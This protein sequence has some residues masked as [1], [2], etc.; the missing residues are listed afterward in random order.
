MW[1]GR[2]HMQTFDARLAHSSCVHCIRNWYYM[3]SPVKECLQQSKSHVHIPG[4]RHGEMAH[5]WDKAAIC[6]LSL[7]LLW[8]TVYISSWLMYKELFIATWKLDTKLDA[9]P[10]LWPYHMVIAKTEGA[11]L[12][13]RGC[14]PAEASNMAIGHRYG[15]IRALIFSWMLDLV[16]LV[17]WNQCS[18]KEKV[19]WF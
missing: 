11:I 2:V 5:W 4:W 8:V 14:E 9:A 16:S 10:Q 12:A 6:S 7:C 13:L 1:D 19:L 15:P 3:L 17:I 18:R